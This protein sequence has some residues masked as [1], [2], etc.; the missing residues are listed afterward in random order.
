MKFFYFSV[1][2]IFCFFHS[3]S[4]CNNK[5]LFII[6]DSGSISFSERIDMQNSIQT[7]SNQ[8]Y[9]DNPLT[10]IGI[11][12]YGQ[13]SANPTSQPSYYVTYPF[14]VNPTIILQ[15]DP[16]GQFMVQDV[17]PNS[18]N[19][20]INDGLFSTGGNFEDATAI[21]LFTDAAVSG[22]CFSVLAN[23]TSCNVPALSCGYDYLNDL[24]QSLGGIPI[25]VYRVMD[26]GTPTSAVGIAQNGGILIEDNNFQVS[27]NQIDQLINS[28]AC[29]DGYF[30][31]LDNCLGETTQFNL[32]TND[33]VT[34][35]SW[36]FGD[37]ATSSDFNPT[38]TYSN[39]GTYDVSLI[40]S[41]DTETLTINE[42]VTIYDN[43]VANPIPDF[44]ICD[45]AN[46]QVELFDLTTRDQY[47]LGSQ[48]DTT[49]SINYFS[50][51]TDAENNDNPLSTNYY[52]TNMEEEIFARIENSQNNQCY[53][54]TSFNVIV[55]ALP[56]AFPVADFVVCDDESNDG[57]A[58]F[59]LT[60][61][62]DQVLN[63][64]SSTTFSTTYHPTY[65]DAIDGANSLPNNYTNQSANEEVFIRVFN[66]DYPDCFNITSL[67]LIVSQQPVAN[68]V[69]DFV[70]CENDMFDLDLTIFN[71]DVLLNQNSSNF[72]VS[73]YYYQNDAINSVNEIN[74]VIS[75]N[76]DMI[77]F[78]KVE[79]NSNLDCYAITPIKLT[80]Y[81]FP[82]EPYEEIKNCFQRN[83]TLEANSNSEEATYLWNTGE[84][85]ESITV[86]NFGTYEVEI[87]INNCTEVKTIDF[88]QD[89]DCNIPQGISPNDDGY[90]DFLDLSFLDMDSIII[91]NRYGTEVYSK[92]NYI[93][94]WKGQTNDGKKLP[95]GT[96]FYVI[97][98]L[99]NK[100]HTG[101]VYLNR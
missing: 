49:F 15:D 73:Y 97:K 2:F 93:N 16:G 81:R 91:Y 52:N 34:S 1:F 31:V 79:N 14:T 78:A 62:N 48:S 7:L 64:Q 95:T 100:T 57:I 25:S 54:I 45:D 13:P 99:S 66:S 90:N 40:I 58:S 37:G 41:N 69:T 70:M 10:E 11:V 38:H 4:Q 22:S 68:A 86:N 51:L 71:Q 72:S 77:V 28:L 83:F 17:L 67:N 65:I 3:F 82:F 101:W 12:Q 30:E 24:S 63:G 92:D 6:D 80:I 26:S 89:T 36:D 59:N 88:I 43:P 33:T 5:I 46:D 8:L 98:T 61:I 94:E 20:M 56:T 85:T 47:I 75:Y 60:L 87:T 35:A 53:E 29:I 74:T 32:T 76:E 27:T 84:T 18:I 23:C 9:T 96:Y 55:A 19:T 39:P 50:S 21:F 42:T 44:I